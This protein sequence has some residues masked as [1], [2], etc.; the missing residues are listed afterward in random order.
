MKTTLR[1]LFLI[2]VVVAL[3]LGWFLDKN[4]CHRQLVALERL[5]DAL[6]D[7]LRSISPANQIRIKVTCSGVERTYGY[8]EFPL[9]EE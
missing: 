4:V 5:N 8:D 3:A 1:E 7:E 9:K 2:V 6:Y